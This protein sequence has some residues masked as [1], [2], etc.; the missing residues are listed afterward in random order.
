MAWSD[1]ARAAAAAARAANNTSPADTAAA[2]M[3]ASGKVSPVW[4]SQ[5]GR[6]MQAASQA[7]LAKQASD[8]TAKGPATGPVDML[9][10][11][12]SNGRSDSRRGQPQGRDSADPFGH[13]VS[14][15]RYC[16][17]RSHTRSAGR[18][19]QARYELVCCSHDP[20]ADWIAGSR[21]RYAAL[22]AD[23]GTCRPRQT[24]RL[25]KIRNV[26]RLDRASVSWLLAQETRKGVRMWSPQSREA[27]AEARR[28]KLYSAAGEASAEAKD[29]RVVPEYPPQSAPP[30]QPAQDVRAARTLGQGH[31]KSSSVSVHAGASGRRR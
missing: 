12:D 6:D 14:Y 22:V 5:F 15:T 30:A 3:H 10:A 13:A 29:M 27:A 20:R 8:M 16:V 1:A 23:R 28:V 19:R 4:N 21:L 24:V 25:P 26:A 11:E 31:A 7:A 18:R 2:R 17:R 9:G